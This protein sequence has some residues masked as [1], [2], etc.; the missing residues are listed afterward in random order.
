MTQFMFSSSVTIIVV[1]ASSR[2][3]P[4]KTPRQPFSHVFEIPMCMVSHSLSDKGIFLT[5]NFF[6]DTHKTGQLP[7]SK[8]Y[9]VWD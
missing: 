3:C 5:Q 1:G 7:T 9:P 8:T 2:V 6:V 4:S